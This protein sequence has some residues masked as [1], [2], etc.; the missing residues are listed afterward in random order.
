MIA[1]TDSS[2]LDEW[3]TL[4]DGVDASAAG[5]LVVAVE[6]AAVAMPDEAT[7]TRT[8]LR[9]RMFRWVQYAS[10]QRWDAWSADLGEAG[11]ARWSAAR[12]AEALEPVGQ[13]D[14]G[15]DARRN[16]LYSFDDDTARQRLVVDGEPSEWELVVV[17]DAD[18]T[19]H[20]GELVV[21]LDGVIAT[22]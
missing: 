20:A 17:L 11:E 5:P 18:A 19:R 13:V 4:L 6:P 21:A 10:G 8:L 9:N 3:Q 1:A 22:A 2:L 16:D 7:A 14:A 15:P 12:L